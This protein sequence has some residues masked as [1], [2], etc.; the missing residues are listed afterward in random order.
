MKQNKGSKAPIPT[1]SS[2][3][4]PNEK[5]MREI[6]RV[7][8][9]FSD[10]SSGLAC[11]LSS[12]RLAGRVSFKKKSAEIPEIKGKSEDS[13]IG[14]A[15]GYLSNNGIAFPIAVPRVLANV[16]PRYEAMMIPVFRQIG[17]RENARASFVSSV[18]SPLDRSQ[19]LSRI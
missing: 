14:R 1:P 2:E 9:F 13:N 4:T 3:R 17:K 6:C 8:S 16:P 12:C 18:I 19:P 5:M 11:S 15:Y 10:L 7:M